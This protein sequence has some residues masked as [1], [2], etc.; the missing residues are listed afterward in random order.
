[1]ANF[2][3]NAAAGIASLAIP[4][5]ELGSKSA[6]EDSCSVEIGVGG[7]IGNTGGSVPHV[8]LWDQWGDRIG[9]YHGAANGH[10]DASSVKT[11]IIKND[12]GVNN[13]PKQP[14]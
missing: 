11:I 13:N 3:I 1:M 9:Q 4:L 14:E 6:P 7:G 8:A 5:G 2:L 10:I 12:Q